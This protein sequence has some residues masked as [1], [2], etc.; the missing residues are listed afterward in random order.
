MDDLFLA[1]SGTAQM[2]IAHYR[3]LKLVLRG[4]GQVVKL[5]LK[6]KFD[7]FL[8]EDLVVMGLISRAESGRPGVPGY[9]TTP[10]GHR[11][12]QSWLQSQQ[13]GSAIPPQ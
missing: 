5:P 9:K 6:F 4:R 8:V 1:N 3:V 12:A 10:S 11:L 2:T 13:A 7:R